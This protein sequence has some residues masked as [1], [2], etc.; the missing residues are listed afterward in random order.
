MSPWIALHATNEGQAPSMAKATRRKMSVSLTHVTRD[1]LALLCS[2]AGAELAATFF[3]LAGMA[4]RV[5]AS[6]V[7]TRKPYSLVWRNLIPGKRHL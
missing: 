5:C 7:S 3:I 2:L 6:H 1:R 4:D